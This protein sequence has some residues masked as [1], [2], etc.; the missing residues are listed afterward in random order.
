[1][2]AFAR[3]SLEALD[4]DVV[5]P[6]RGREGELVAFVCLSSKRSG[7]VYTPTDLHLLAAVAAEAS[8]QL[9]LGESIRMQEALRRYVPGAIAAELAS[10]R[11]VEADE[12][13]VS[14]LFVDLRGHTTYAETRR[15][16]DVFSTVN[17]YTEA[18]SRAV[19]DRGG[20]VVEFAG[21]GMM[22]VFGAPT[23]M[24]GKESAAVAASEAICRAVA[25]LAD[26]TRERGEPPLAVGVGVATGWAFVGNVDAVD[27]AIWTALGDR[28]N[29]AARLQMLTR[30]VD[31]AIVIDARTWSALDPEARRRFVRRDAVSIR[32]RHQAEDVYVFPL[33]GP[34]PADRTSHGT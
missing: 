24:P 34:A 27:R 2:A 20:S 8:N 29:L 32:G 12:R 7:D 19:R 16:R 28:V 1:L 33:P 30:E 17:R 22:A 25:D 5:L 13:D 21:D 15:A 26:D 18:V 6:I 23:P 14:I 4:A 3:A 10:G 31:A 11:E 9:V